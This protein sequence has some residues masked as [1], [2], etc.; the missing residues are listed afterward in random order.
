MK[1]SLR[2]QG[3]TKRVN[4]QSKQGWPHHG[5]FRRSLQCGATTQSKKPARTAHWGRSTAARRARGAGIPTSHWNKALLFAANATIYQVSPLARKG[6]AH[7]DRQSRRQPGRR[8]RRQETRRRPAFRSVPDI[9]APAQARR[10]SARAEECRQAEGIARSHGVLRDPDRSEDR[11][12]RRY[13]HIY[14]L[15][16]GAS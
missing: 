14:L 11:G 6:Y 2:S 3:A 13:C 12:P 4:A 7:V 8:A 16:E 15:I 9:P 1:P 10:T 5:L